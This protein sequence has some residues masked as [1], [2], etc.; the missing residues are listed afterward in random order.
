MR[1]VA[2]TVLMAISM[3]AILFAAPAQATPLCS[4]P[5]GVC[6]RLCRWGIVCSR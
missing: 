5:A 3:S 6:D 4:D 1:R 2:G